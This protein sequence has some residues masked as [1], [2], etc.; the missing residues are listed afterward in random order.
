MVAE[1]INVTLIWLIFEN[2][3]KQKHGEGNIL[4]SQYVAISF[5]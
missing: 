3:G 4:Q 2:A 1:N 5:F